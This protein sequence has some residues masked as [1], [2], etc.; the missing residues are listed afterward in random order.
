LIEYYG[1]DT[2]YVVDLPDGTRIRVREGSAPA[3]RRGDAVT[4]GFVGGPTI[5]YP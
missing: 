1:H 5:A 3:V 4:V 2:V